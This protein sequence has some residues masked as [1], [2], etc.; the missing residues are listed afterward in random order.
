MEPHSLVDFKASFY[1]FKQI[2]QTKRRY[3]ASVISVGRC[4]WRDSCYLLNILYT[5]V[6]CEVNT[7]TNVTVLHNY[8][9]FLFIVNTNNV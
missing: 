5:V 9:L 2:E 7:N 1:C 8:A 6:I 4:K 3:L